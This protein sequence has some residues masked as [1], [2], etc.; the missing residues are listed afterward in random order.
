MLRTVDVHELFSAGDIFETY[1]QA[2]SRGR[3]CIVVEH[4]EKYRK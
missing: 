4:M 3:S 2:L 1:R